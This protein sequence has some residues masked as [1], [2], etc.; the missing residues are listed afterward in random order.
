MKSFRALGVMTLALAASHLSAQSIKVGGD[1][2]FWYTQLC[3][4]YTSP[5][6]RD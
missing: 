4:L 1:V 6:P 5:S 3:L 2:Q